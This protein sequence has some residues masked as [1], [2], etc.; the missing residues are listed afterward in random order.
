MP[1]L[2]HL[3]D[4][5]AEQLDNK[6]QGKAFYT[7]LD[8]RFAYGQVPLDEETAKHCNFQIIGGKPTGTYRFI[9]GFYGLTIMPTEFRKA[10]DQ[11]LG[12]LPNT[13]VF[14]DDILIVTRG[15]QEKHFEIVKQVLK[16]LDNANIILKWEKCK[17]AAEEL[18]WLGYKL[19][20][21]S[22]VQ[23]ITEKLTPKSLK[24]L[25]SYL[26]AV[27]QLNRF[28]PNLAQLCHELRP[29]LKKDQPWNWGEKH[30]KAIQVINEKV[31]QVAEVGHFK[32]SSPIR[33]ICDASKAGL[34]AVLQQIDE[35]N[36]KN[37]RPIHFASRILT[38]LESKYSIN[39][40]ELLAIVWAIEHFKNY[41]YGTKFKKISDHKA[42]TFVLKGNKKN[43][44]YS[45]RLTRWVDR[46]FPF[47]FEIAHAPG[48]TMGIA[49]YLSRH[50][51]PIGGES[52]KAT[53]LWNTWFTVS[54][55]NNLNAVL[56]NEFNEPI[57]GR[58][59]IK[60]QR[61]DKRSK[62][63]HWPIQSKQTDACEN[64]KNANSSIDNKMGQS[65]STNYL[66]GT[67]IYQV[68]SKLQP[69][70]KLANQIG[71]NL[72]AA[73]YL[74]DEFLQKIIAIVK[75]PTKGKIKN[76]DS[77]W[78]ERFQ[79][80]SLDK[81]DL[82]YLDDRLVIPKILQAPIKNWLHWGHPGRD[83][84]LQQISDIWWPRI[85]RDITLL[86]K[87]CSSCQEAGKS[88]KPVLKQQKFGKLPIPE[89]T[90]DEIAI[91]FA[92]PF[93]I[94]RSSK[95][96]LIVSVDSKTGWQDAKF[97][98]A[99]TT[100]KVIEFLQKYIAD[101]GIPKQIRKDPGTAFNSHKFKEFCENF[102][103]KH[104][105][106][107]VND[108]KGN[109]KVERLIRTI[110]ERLRA[111]KNIIL[112]KNNTGLSEML[113]ALRSAKRPNNFA[114]QNYTTTENSLLSKILL[115]P[116]QTKTTL[117]QRTTTTSSWN[118]QIFQEN[119]TP[120]YW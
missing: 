3:V 6:E 20:Q 89:E 120:R 47:E 40:L 36:E 65:Q 41:L 45:S 79:A 37:W 1:N 43:K 95:R 115:L 53:E 52:I 84:M 98:R 42:L 28:I 38:P 83:A 46:L 14:L 85:H 77:P 35:N 16:K 96:Y 103:I 111:N 87:S 56:A 91:D 118:C 116:N 93:K 67:E 78:R 18:E 114:Q 113:Y 69:K 107:P 2:E 105:K 61:N 88:I 102:F 11:E 58:K 60:V 17:F 81:N 19:S 39:E 49:D 30:D 74:D 33:I 51:S 29:L 108:H 4:L 9:T 32:R 82:L 110:N 109:G 24:E 26:G 13:Y 21:N 75:N 5:V 62:S 68:S 27:N 72:L 64:M 76:L 119:K 66:T 71:Q 94:A 63:A 100:R 50:P 31:K 99:P 10:M 80:L 54:H 8:M 23:A 34:G 12:N 25:R 44:T 22:K 92:G 106:C 57:R 117:F 104:V 59:R 112:E 73:N 70:L 90:N 55:V 86:A 7:S 15:S 48:R 97:L 101:N